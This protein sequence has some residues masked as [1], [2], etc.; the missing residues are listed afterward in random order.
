MLSRKRKRKNQTFMNTIIKLALAATL[1]IFAQNVQAQDDPISIERK[2]QNAKD[3]IEYLKGK[4]Q[5]LIDGEK[6]G[7]KNRV[8]F[9]NSEL[10]NGRI[11]EEEAEQQKKAAAEKAAL[12]IENE[13]AII[14]N[15]IALVE[16]NGK[17][18]NNVGTQ[19][20]L[21]FGH[22]DGDGK[23]VFG[24]TVDN[25][26]VGSVTYDKRTYSEFVL[27]FGLNNAITDV[28]E[29]GDDFSIGRS[30]FFELGVAWKTRILDNSGALQFKYGLSL[31]INKLFAKDNQTLVESAEVSNFQEFPSELRKSQLRF[32]NLVVPVHIEFGGWKKEE[33]D[34]K[35]RYRIAGKFRM[36]IGGYA[37][38]RLGTQ[39]KLKFRE[40]GERIKTKEK[41][42]FGGDNFVYG[43][44][45]YIRLSNDL[46]LYGKY[47]LSSVLDTQDLGEVNNVSL[48]I[49]WDW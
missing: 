6:Q 39:Q 34:D 19:V 4:R 40:D 27:A 15:Q 20:L 48:G 28:G 41:Q 42:D 37:G 33:E 14:D 17:I 29:L 10:E 43:L 8:Y 9:I 21:G 24:L 7:L 30:R 12:N 31:Q 45:S 23:Q 11:T 13:T 2:L 49:R 16:R 38:V 25:G 44:S 5:L 26:K 35:V 36:G 18:N 3:Q 1:A 47:D 32:S 22:Q 46:S